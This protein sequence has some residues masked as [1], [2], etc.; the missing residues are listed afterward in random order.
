MNETY[1]EEMIEYMIKWQQECDEDLN[2][3]ICGHMPDTLEYMARNLAFWKMKQLEYAK[4]LNYMSPID[5]KINTIISAGYNAA[6]DKLSQNINIFDKI[7]FRTNRL[8]SLYYC[9]IERVIKIMVEEEI[10]THSL[11]SAIMLHELLNYYNITNILVKGYKYQI[12]N[13]GIIMHFWIN[14]E[15]P[16]DIAEMIVRRIYLK[17]KIEWPKINTINIMN[18]GNKNTHNVSVTT[19]IYDHKLIKSY[20]LY[21]NNPTHYWDKSPYSHIRDKILYS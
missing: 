13:K 6:M 16:I 18:L 8:M 10:L 3:Y 19:Q 17:R 15:E 2:Q 20:Y 21:L 7:Y 9:L 1:H 11:V 4:P 14:H 5:I 12:D